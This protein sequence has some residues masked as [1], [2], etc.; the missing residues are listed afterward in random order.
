[1]IADWQTIVSSDNDVHECFKFIAETVLC[2]AFV[3]ERGDGSIASYNCRVER[4]GKKLQVFA[5]EPQ[6]TCLYV[7]LRSP[8]SVFFDNGE[9]KTL[10]DYESMTGT[11]YVE[12]LDTS[13]VDRS[14]W[15]KSGKTLAFSWVSKDRHYRQFS[16]PPSTCCTDTTIS[17]WR[18]ERIGLEALVASRKNIGPGDTFFIY[19]DGRSSVRYERL[20]EGVQLSEK[21]RILRESMKADG[22]KNGL[23]ELEN[24]LIP[25]R[26]VGMS[27]MVPSSTII[28]EL[29]SRISLLS[30]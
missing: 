13:E 22:D 21:I 19:P 14:A 6:I 9:I 4:C 1:M 17:V 28:N 8:L 27:N 25:V 15:K 16:N 3:I 23:L 12:P 26:K 30:R 10:G 29:S 24:A 5:D 20:L 11:G 18:G 7:N 2:N